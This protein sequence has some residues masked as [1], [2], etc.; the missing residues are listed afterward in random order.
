MTRCC[1]RDWCRLRFEA[2]LNPQRNP[3]KPARVDIK[4][5]LNM[6]ATSWCACP[7]PI[8]RHQA[9]LNLIL[10]ERLQ[11]SKQLVAVHGH[12]TFPSRRRKVPGGVS[13][14]LVGR[15]VGPV[16]G[17]R[18]IV[19][20]CWINRRVIARWI[21]AIGGRVVRI[22]RSIPI[23]PVTSS[24]T[25]FLD[26]SRC[27]CSGYSWQSLRSCCG[28]PWAHAHSARKNDGDEQHS[29]HD[30]TSLSF[31]RTPPIPQRPLQLSL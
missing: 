3:S 15:V 20:I 31:L 22:G 2:S 28:G 8:L 10:A 26:E 1:R 19:R 7:L 13:S 30:L 25:N 11:F 6:S 24:P 12:G 29:T 27:L 17:I 5:G 4:R 21:V 16:I 9:G 23:A 14:L 18:R